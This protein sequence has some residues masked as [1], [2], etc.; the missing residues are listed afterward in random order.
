LPAPRRCLILLSDEHNP[1]FASCARHALARTPRLDALAARGTRFASAYTAS[2]ICVPAR[3]SLATGRYVHRI[4]YWDNALAYDGRVPGWGHA[5][6]AAG[7]RVES[8]GKLHYRNAQDPTGFDRQLLPMHVHGG[9]GQVW[10]A[11]RDPL[12]VGRPAPPMLAERREG[13]SAYNRYDRSIAAAARAWLEEAAARPRESWCLFV[14]FVAPHFPLVV[15]PRYLEAFPLERVTLPKRVAERHPW[16]EAMDAYTRVESGWGD[17]DRR[18]AVRLYLGLCAFLDERVGEVLDALERCGLAQDTLVLYTSDH[19]DNAGARGL[20]GKSTL[21]REAA[22]VPMILAGPGVAAGRVEHAPASLVDIAPTLLEWFGLEADAALP[23]ASLLRAL[24]P[25]RAVFSE[26][27]AIGAPSGAFMLRRGRW[28]Y[29]HYVG[30]EPEL[31]DLEDDPE[32]TRNVARSAPARVREHEALLRRLCD[33][34]AVDRAAKRDQ[35]A[36]VA[37]FGGREKALLT[38]TPGATPAPVEAGH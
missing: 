32:E 7:V 2:P 22:G 16:I 27:H 3:A 30:F 34:E 11:V 9:I 24:D 25:A 20:W 31:F 37:R 35:A 23:G 15:P 13:E 29:H 6:R 10:G 5:L 36:L 19:G 38:G 4:G 17:E 18:R 8:I 28:K 33:P 1:D 14:G 12:P 26:Y 21:Y